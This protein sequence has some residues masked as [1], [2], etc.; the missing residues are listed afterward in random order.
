M[1]TRLAGALSIVTTIAAG[2]SAE[3]TATPPTTSSTQP[4]LTEPAPTETPPRGALPSASDVMRVWLP[5]GVFITPTAASGSELQTLNPDLPTRP[6]FT[7]GQAVTTAVSPDQK[8]LLVLTSGY[9]RNVGADGK[10]AVAESN[11]YVFVYDIAAH[12]P[13][14]R[15]VIQL[16]NTFNGLAFGPSGDRFYVSGGVDDN[17]HELVR[18]ASGA[19]A[20]LLP[21]IKLGHTAGGLGLATPAAAAGVAVDK[22][23][24]RAVVANFENDSITVVDLGLRQAVAELDLRPGKIDPARRGQPGGE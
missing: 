24:R 10:R 15:Q 19:F 9:N 5:T 7:A 1:R 14:R 8:T 21:A 11:E 22:S 16:P 3:P 6:D 12:A 17:L 23:G 13:V 2:C 18:G 4:A 20:G